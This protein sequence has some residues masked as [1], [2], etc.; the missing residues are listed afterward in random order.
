MLSVEKVATPATAATVAV[1]ASVPP[2]GLVPIDNV[3]ASLK[4]VNVF[5]S[6]SCAVICTGG[7]VAP[8]VVVTGCAVQTSCVAGAGVRTQVALVV[9]GSPGAVTRTV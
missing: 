4:P 5:P 2:A 9:A 8:A 3:T 6:E 1:P 7:S